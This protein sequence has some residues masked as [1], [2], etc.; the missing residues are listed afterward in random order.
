M[1]WSGVGEG[2]VEC[3]CGGRESGDVSGVGVEWVV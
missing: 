3:G 2:C 1:E